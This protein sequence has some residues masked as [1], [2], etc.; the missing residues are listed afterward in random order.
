M[1]M[2][3][4]LCRHGMSD[5]RSGRALPFVDALGQSS[6]RSAADSLAAS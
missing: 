2:A 4:V 5:G 1:T 6:Q 3:I